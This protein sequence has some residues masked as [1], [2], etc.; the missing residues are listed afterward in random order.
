M[1]K[2][3]QTIITWL[4]QFTARARESRTKWKTKGYYDVRSV[5]HKRLSS[6]RWVYNRTMLN[7]MVLKYP[8]L[9]FYI[10]KLFVFINILIDLLH[11]YSIINKLFI[12]C[13]RESPDKYTK[14]V[15]MI[16]HQELDTKIA[17]RSSHQVFV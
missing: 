6:I 17:Q 1:F 10:L 16:A 15:G 2:L 9:R 4:P 8:V 11:D 12:I 5:R 7:L 3:L 14:V 13:R